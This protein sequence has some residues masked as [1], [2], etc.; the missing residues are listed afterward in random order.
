MAKLTVNLYD[1]DPQT[2]LVGKRSVLIGRSAD[3]EVQIDDPS[4]SACHAQLVYCA[5]VYT[6]TD[7]KSTNGTKVNGQYIKTHLLRDSDRIRFGRVTCLFEV[8]AE[9]SPGKDH[10][11][12]LLRVSRKGKLLGYFTPD[13][14]RESMK[15]GELRPDDTVWHD[16]SDSSTG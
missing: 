5:G 15:R 16:S 9:Y 12:K 8:P 1:Q 2:H 3:T 7:L 14:A 13:N 6:L 11:K 10:S 4:V